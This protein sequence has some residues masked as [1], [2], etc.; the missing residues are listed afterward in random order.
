[1]FEI[2]KITPAKAAEY[3]HKNTNNRPVTQNHVKMLSTAMS[4]GEWMF[5]GETIKLSE[6]GVLLDGQHRLL[7]I[8]DSNTTQKMAVITN[9]KDAA[10]DTLD[11][12]KRRSASDVLAI[13]G[14]AYSVSLS[15]TARVLLRL[16]QRESI[17][18]GYREYYSPHAILE[19]VESRPQLIA[20][21]K[22][23]TTMIGKRLAS[24]TV[25]AFSHYMFNALNPEKTNEFFKML[26]TGFGPAYAPPLVLREQLLQARVHK[27]TLKNEEQLYYFSKA[28]KHFL[29]DETP[30]K[31]KISQ[32][33]SA[34]DALYVDIFNK[35]ELGQLEK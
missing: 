23:Y 3:L 29:Q 7:A 8:I 13:K 1:M 17:A 4:A 12:G 2:L 30:D 21:T 14:Y 35:M 25:L 6:T 33:A 15:A 22:F 24:N 10:F 11:T 26:K 27:Q 18:R 20:D 32:H 31:I 19:E 16:R 34:N 9:L 28:F 5:N